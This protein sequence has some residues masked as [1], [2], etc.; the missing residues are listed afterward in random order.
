MVLQAGW[1]IRKTAGEFRGRDDASRGSRSKST[2][3]VL[4]QQLGDGRTV[5]EPERKCSGA[6]TRVL[7]RKRRQS[8]RIART[9]L[10]LTGRYKAGRRGATLGGAS[11]RSTRRRVNVPVAEGLFSASHIQIVAWNGLP[12][13]ALRFH[14]NVQRHTQ[15]SPRPIPVNTVRPVP[16]GKI[17]TRAPGRR[18]IVARHVQ[19]R[20][21]CGLAWEQPAPAVCVA[22]RR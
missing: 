1:R 6:N 11:H 22:L 7:E 13:F 15:L 10:S 9:A 20:S 2:P 18:G 4:R 5:A 21:A 16:Q 19:F 8:T 3:V 14:R 17:N 12:L